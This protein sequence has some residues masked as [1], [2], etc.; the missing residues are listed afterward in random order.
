MICKVFLIFQ[1]LRIFTSLKCARLNGPLSTIVYAFP[2]H[3]NV[4]RKMI[5][6]GLSYKSL[7]R[8][9]QVSDKNDCIT[10]ES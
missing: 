2:S 3:R 10:G 4:K 1:F 9:G 5:A 7:S 6:T 8:D